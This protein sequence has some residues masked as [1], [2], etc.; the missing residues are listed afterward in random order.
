MS[1]ADPPASAPP[2]APRGGG[3]LIAAGLILGPIVGLMVGQVS[4]GLVAGGL[5]GVFAAIWMTLADRR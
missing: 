3:C 1:S 5:L 2:P 4:A